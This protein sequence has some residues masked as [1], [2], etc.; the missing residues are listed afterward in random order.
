MFEVQ[1]YDNIQDLVSYVQYGYYSLHT[2][3]CNC[4]S[5]H[6]RTHALTHSRMFATCPYRGHLTSIAN[7]GC[8]SSLIK[9]YQLGNLEM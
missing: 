7:M 3:L 8:E 9:I 1:F 2:Q 4:I 5:L 6:A